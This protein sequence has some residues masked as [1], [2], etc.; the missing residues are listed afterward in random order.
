MHKTM[1]LGLIM[2]PMLSM[3]AYE[4]VNAFLSDKSEVK[5]LIFLSENCPC[6]KSHVDH[7]NEIVSQ[8]P[9][10][11]FFGVISEPA[12]NSK[13][14]TKLDDYFTSD[15]FRFPIIADSSQILV[16][17]YKALKTPHVTLF[18]N[19]KVIYEGGLTNRKSFKESG[20]KYFAENLELLAKGEPLKYK[21]GM[22]LGC[23][24]RRVR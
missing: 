9:D 2:W 11:K 15:R 20:K 10:V 16:K 6:S 22:S 19:D 5:A 7:L 24:I 21:N 13:A 17:K 23:Y 4:G 3:A 8:Y 18:K 14:Q 1:L 12:K